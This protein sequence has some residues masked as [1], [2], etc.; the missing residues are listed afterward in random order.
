MAELV[1][2]V[3]NTQS[4][5]PFL[6]VYSNFYLNRAQLFKFENHDKG[7]EVLGWDNKK[8]LWNIIKWCFKNGLKHVDLKE[9]MNDY[10][11]KLS[12]DDLRE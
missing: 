3:W 10:T 1:E 8:D 4:Q 2:T 5:Q 7:L 6:N 9:N 12:T 11:M